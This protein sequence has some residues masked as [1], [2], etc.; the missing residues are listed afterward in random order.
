MKLAEID[1]QVKRLTQQF[2]ALVE[3]FNIKSNL[4]KDK[5]F[6]LPD[7]M[8]S[9]AEA[10]EMISKYQFDIYE[11]MASIGE[12][13]V[14]NNWQT[15]ESMEQISLIYYQKMNEAISANVNILLNKHIRNAKDMV[16][17][18]KANRYPKLVKYSHSI[19]Y[20]TKQRQISITE[21]F[22][23]DVR[24]VLIDFHNDLKL[25]GAY[26]NGKSWAYTIQ[27]DGSVNKRFSISEYIKTNLK[28]KIFHP[29][30][31]SL[32]YVEE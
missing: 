23:K 20:D 5:V 25:F 29:N 18:N 13:S 6:T 24:K 14:L 8:R 10:K 7:V 19:I 4:E 22:R 30:V 32:A 28:N 2:S 27:S 16:I 3:L 9:R 26:N 21:K 1:L 15:Q 17:R 12:E 11:F 31:Q